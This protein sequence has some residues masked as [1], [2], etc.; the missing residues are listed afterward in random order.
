MDQSW[1][2]SCLG[3]VL[4]ALCIITSHVGGA[5]SGGGGGGA[6]AVVVL[7]LVVVV[8]VVVRW[9]AHQ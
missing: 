3:S 5:G 8:Q 9:G 1:K 4:C 2:L 6:T 7:M